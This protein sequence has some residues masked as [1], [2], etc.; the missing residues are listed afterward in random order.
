MDNQEETMAYKF[1]AI[2][3]KLVVVIF[4]GLIIGF[5]IIYWK[6]TL[7]AIVITLVILVLAKDHLEVKNK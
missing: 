3:G 6:F 4:T 7:I 2:V 5:G 1:G